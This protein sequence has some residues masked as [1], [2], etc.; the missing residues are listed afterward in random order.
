MNFDE[1]WGP[2]PPYHYLM[3]QCDPNYISTLHNQWT[4]ELKAREIQA[5]S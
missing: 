3:Q 1:I 4:L 5:A 2:Q